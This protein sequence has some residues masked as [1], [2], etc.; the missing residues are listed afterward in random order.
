MVIRQGEVYWVDFG[1]PIGSMPG[2]KR[3][4]VIIQN[5]VFNASKIATVIVAAV[6]SNMRLAQAPG[7][8]ALRKKEAGLPKA[9]VVNVSQLMTVDKSMLQEKIG[10]LS[11]KRFGEILDGVHLVVNPA[12]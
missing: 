1:E 4:C 9:S 5:D 8:V 10:K 3:P 7:N 11:E 2:F 12:I 6:T